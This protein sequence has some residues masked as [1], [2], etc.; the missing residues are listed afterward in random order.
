MKYEIRQEFDATAG[1]VISAMMHPEVAAFLTGHMK[2]LR[3][4]ELLERT[5]TDDTIVRRVRYRIQPVIEKIGPKKIPPEAFEWVE[6]STFDKK[7]RV[8]TYKNIPTKAKIAK[9]FENHGE[10]R[11]TDAGA[12]CTRI[13]SGELKIHFPLLGSVA[14][15]MIYKKA[16][17]ILEEEAAALRLFMVQ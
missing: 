10:I 12:R 9:M 4:M 1:Q 17:E 8:M 5:E 16:A 14:E 6:Q 3:E 7:R 2:S 11:I 13:M 15:K